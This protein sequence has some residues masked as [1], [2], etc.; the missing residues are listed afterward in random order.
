MR[1]LPSPPCRHTAASHFVRR[2]VHTGTALTSFKTNA[3]PPGA[4]STL[5]SDYLVAAQLGR[6]GGLHFWT[7]H[8]DQLHQRCF[9]PEPLTAVAASPGGVFCAAGGA[10][11]AVYI[12]E[13][14]SGRMLKSWPAHYKVRNGLSLATALLKHCSNT[15]QTASQLQQSEPAQQP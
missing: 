10:S 5:G 8:K 4:L 12:W 6:G 9:A 2:D 7:W 11:G 15:A 1:D 14:S 13:T 3:C